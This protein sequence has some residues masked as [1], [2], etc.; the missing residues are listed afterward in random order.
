MDLFNEIR[1][2]VLADARVAYHPSPD[3]GLHPDAIFAALRAEIPWEL[4]SVNI[5]GQ[6]I[7]QPRLSSWHGEVVHTY[8][9]L[10]HLLVPHPW[11]G[12][13]AH[14]RERVEA[15]C[16]AR[17]NSMLA[18]LYR[19]GQDAIGWHA[20]DEPELGPAPVIASL[21]FGAERVFHMRGKDDHAKVKRI[22]LEHG[23]LL[24]MAGTMQ[25]HWQHAVMRTAKPIGERINLTFRL[26]V[27]SE[28]SSIREAN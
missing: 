1:P 12:V 27:G 20:D 2:I 3:L 10:A 11:S 8:S 9:T 23:S 15:I 17:F 18:N 5:H 13:V 6:I 14:L 24:I 19:N 28:S 25:R 26:T 4:H 21:S 22:T 16:A 7:P